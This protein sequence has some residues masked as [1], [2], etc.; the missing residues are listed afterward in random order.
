MQKVLGCVLI[1][2][3]VVWIGLSVLVWLGVIHAAGA[4]AVGSASGWDVLIALIKKL[5]WLTIVGLIQIYAGIKMFG[6]N[7]SPS[8]AGG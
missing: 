5:P 3:G 1:L 4:M 7:L 8:A 6:V 2:V